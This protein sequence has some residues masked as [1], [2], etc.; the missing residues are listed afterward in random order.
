[1]ETGR[2]RPSSSESA[3]RRSTTGSSITASINPR[4]QE[5]E[6][7]ALELNRLGEVMVEASLAGPCPIVRLDPARESHEEESFQ[8]RL[9]PEA[10]RHLEAVEPGQTDV[11]DRDVGAQAPRRVDG[12]RAIVRDVRLVPLEQR[13][14]ETIPDEVARG[15]ALP[16]REV[17]GSVR[18]VGDQDHGTLAA[19]LAIGTQEVDAALLAEPAG[20]EVGVVATGTHRLEPRLERPGPLELDTARHLGDERGPAAAARRRRPVRSETGSRRL[21]P[22]PSLRL[23]YDPA[24]TCR[25]CVSFLWT[26][27]ADFLVSSCAV[28]LISC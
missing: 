25:V 14:V 6:L 1:M 5:D 2:R 26:F 3:S 28:F 24:D 20:D 17:L 27:L 21:A 12:G 11:E 22:T 4:F 19:G 13:R 23:W 9:R 7:E 10:T 16:G 8:F 15:A 18:L